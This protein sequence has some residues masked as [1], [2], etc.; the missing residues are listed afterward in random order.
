MKKR[1]H[2]LGYLI[3][4]SFIGM[5]L[6]CDHNYLKYDPNRQDALYMVGGDS[7]E[8]WFYEGSPENTERNYRSIHVV[9]MPS[10]VDRE[11]KVVI[12]DRLTTGQEGIHYKLDD[13]YICP[14]NEVVFRIGVTLYRDRDP[15]LINRPVSVAFQVVENDNF[16]ILPGFTGDNISC[17]IVK[18]KPQPLPEWWDTTHLGEFV[19]EVAFQFMEIY[20][21]LKTVNPIIYERISGDYGE[22]L[23]LD[24]QGGY[25]PDGTRRE[26]VWKRY[27]ILL[28]KFIVR[29][30]YD[31]FADPA[32][33]DPE[34][35]IPE[36][37]Y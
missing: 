18:V 14:A 25:N 32:H 36:P 21:N 28:L 30:L 34:I 19:P 3:V 5:I 31:Y 13:K 20:R 1:T 2:L 22:E 6:G 26:G 33:A 24:P 8:H 37:L 29:P 16:R 35:Q 27:E 9:G 10:P 12:V 11:V 4:V 23:E 7:T 15:E 17:V